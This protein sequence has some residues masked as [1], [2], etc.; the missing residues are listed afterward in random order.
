MSEIPKIPIVPEP[1]AAAP[2]AEPPAM[3][4]AVFADGGDDEAD[5]RER[6]AAFDAVFRWRGRE[7]LPFSSSRKSLFLQ[8]RLAMGAPDL[9]A[10]LR[11]LDAFLGDAARILFLCSH[12]PEDRLA[13]G[14]APGWGQLR[15]NPAA[16]QAEIDRW[17]D[18]NIP[19]GSESEAVVTGYR[20]YAAAG[21]NRHEPAPGPRLSADE[22]GN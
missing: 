5:E 20:I 13:G 22:L 19:G 11:D 6:E 2:V 10:C 14:Q 16:L 1:V 15:A 18:E 17:T 7:L 8:L 9:T 4:V 21:R 3:P 12:A